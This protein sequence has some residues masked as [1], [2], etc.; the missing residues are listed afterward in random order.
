MLASCAV[1]G[2]LPP[3][4][5]GDE[6]FIDGGVV[7]SVP[8]GRAVQLG[9]TEVYVLHVGRLERPLSAPR[10]PW[11]VGQV[12]FE[13]ARRHRFVEE[14]AKLPDGVKVHLLPSGDDNTPL[15]SLRYR[16]PAGVADRIERGYEA[17]RAFLNGGS[18]PE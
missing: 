15:V 12:T 2:L 8:V 7:D 10:N 11:E 1:P 17:T 3:V 18:P 9:A 16:S 6:T 5:I 13:I 4:R 14:M